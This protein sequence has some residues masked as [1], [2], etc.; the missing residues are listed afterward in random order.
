MVYV[1]WLT[2]SQQQPWDIIIIPA[3][4]INRHSKTSPW[5]WSPKWKVEFPVYL[6]SDPVLG[7][8]E[9]D[10]VWPSRVLLTVLCASKS[11]RE[12]WLQPRYFWFDASRVC[13]QNLHFE[14]VPGDAG[15][16][17][18]LTGTVPS[19][20]SLESDLPLHLAVSLTSYATL[21]RIPSLFNF[22]PGWW[23]WTLSY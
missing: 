21:S 4:L 13:P 3:L 7:K 1:H 15:P 9:E 6:A 8:R 10:R 18:R 19:A 17:L 14:D 2:Q 5:S 11:P 23:Q 22:T 12:G 20:P 16:T